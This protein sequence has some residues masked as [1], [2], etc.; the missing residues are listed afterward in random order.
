MNMANDS[1]KPYTESRPAQAQGKRD[2]AAGVMGEAREKASEA[3]HDAR[4]KA[5]TNLSSQKQ[6]AT[7]QLANVSSALRETSGNLR[8]S[9][10]E[11]I[12]GYF[13]SAA[14]QV[15]RLS[16]YFRDRSVGELVDEVEDIAR[17]EPALFLGG[18]ALLGILGSRFFK[19]SERRRMRDF[20][21]GGSRY[22]DRDESRY[23]D[24][25]RMRSRDDI[26]RDRLRTRDV[27]V[28]RTSDTDPFGTPGDAF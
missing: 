28:P 4:Q 19:S 11:S 14:E 18:A 7:D 6:R 20:D 12:A 22:I 17:R 15:D 27:S 9:E 24:R 5:E 1:S 13:E 10:Q 26:D 8:D 21:R 23:I 2:K 25:D 16:G 3:V